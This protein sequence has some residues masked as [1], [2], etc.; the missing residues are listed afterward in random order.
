MDDALAAGLVAAAGSGMPSTAYALA[1]GRD[2]LEATLAAGSILLPDEERRL[3]LLIAAGVVHLG[4]SLGWAALLARVLPPRHTAAW[5]AAAGLAIAALDLG[6]GGRRFPRIRALPLAP[7]VADHVAY[8]A[9]AGA[10]L[11]RR[12]S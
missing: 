5:G 2:P 11:A 8:G 7:Q 9:L 6:L 4:L 10:T 1:A 12:R 3:Q